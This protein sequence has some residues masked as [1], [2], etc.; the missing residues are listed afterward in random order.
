MEVE[1]LQRAI[2]DES[3]QFEGRPEEGNCLTI[4]EIVRLFFIL[5]LR[6]M[7]LKLELK[8]VLIEEW[9]SRKIENSMDIWFDST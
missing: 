5:W 3:S 8:Q 2:E 1:N 9:G 7:W 4:F 6:Q